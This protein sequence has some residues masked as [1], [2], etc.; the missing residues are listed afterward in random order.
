MESGAVLAES[1]DWSQLKAP[2]AA[3]FSVE[4]H[5]LPDVYQRQVQFDSFG[6]DQTAIYE[7]FA[8]VPGDGDLGLLFESP[9]HGLYDQDVSGSLRRPFEFGRIGLNE[10]FDPVRYSQ[11]PCQGPRR[12][13]RPGVIVEQGEADIGPGPPMRD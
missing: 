9:L 8:E 5:F 11:L 6:H 7:L 1:Q 3:G 2:T 13:Q 12:F 4:L 10:R